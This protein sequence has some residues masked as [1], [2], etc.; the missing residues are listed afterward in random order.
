LREFFRAALALLRGMKDRSLR[1]DLELLVGAVVIGDAMLGPPS[2]GCVC[3]GSVRFLAISVLYLMTKA[4][5]KLFRTAFG[6]PVLPSQELLSPRDRLIRPLVA[7]SDK[8]ID[9][10]CLHLGNNVLQQ[11]SCERV[12]RFLLHHPKAHDVSLL[13]LDL[14]FNQRWREQIIKPVRYFS[15]NCLVIV[16]IELNKV[17]HAFAS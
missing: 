5:W 9:F 13:F 1:G 17:P 6:G 15:A 2:A 11:A 14:I 4:A 12:G 3:M 7:L 10:L 16:L 8:S